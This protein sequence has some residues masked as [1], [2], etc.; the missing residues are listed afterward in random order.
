MFNKWHAQLENGLR[1]D[2]LPLALE[3]DLANYRSLIPSLA[4]LIHLADGGVAEITVAALD[5]AIR[6]GQYLESHACRLYATAVH[7]DVAAG[8]ALAKQILDGSL[9][10][11]FTV[12]DVYRPCWSGLTTSEEAQAAIELLVDLDWLDVAEIPTPGRKRTEHRINP[13]LRQKHPG[14]ELPELP[15]D[16]FGSFGSTPEEASQVF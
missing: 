1:S 3:S 7:S 15:K 9:A 8:R 12:R 4:L 16:P 14:K 10:D 2:E 5:T 11:G 6:W 13:R